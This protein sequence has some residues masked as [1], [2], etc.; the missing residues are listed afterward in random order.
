MI[1]VFIHA[2]DGVDGWAAIKI[3]VNN[4]EYV[5]EDLKGMKEWVFLDEL[6]AGII[7]HL[8]KHV[9][10]YAFS[11]YQF[12]TQVDDE[13]DCGYLKEKLEAYQR[14]YIN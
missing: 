7:R 6:V 1:P 8:K 11:E 9:P 5:C 2:C 10:Q 4:G 13:D 14:Q 12:T 3:D